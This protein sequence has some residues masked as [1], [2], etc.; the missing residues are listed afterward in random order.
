MS[1]NE[2][3]ITTITDGV[4]TLTINRPQA[5]NATSPEML[6][7]IEE[8]F[9]RVEK[10]P[11]ARCLVI[12]AAGEHFIAGGD[13]G[14][15]GPALQMTPEARSKEFGQRVEEALPLYQ[16]LNRMPK[17]IVVVA[18]GAIAG[19]GIAMALAADLTLISDTAFYFFAH[20]HLGLSLDGAL[21]YYLP[22]AVGPRKA[23]ELALLNARVAAPE[24]LQIGLANRMIADAELDAQADKLIKQ[25]ASGATYAMART[26][27]L[28]DASM[29]NSLT[30]QFRLEGQGVAACVATDDWLEGVQAFLG[31]RKPIFHG[32]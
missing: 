11:Q 14:S 7:G 10:D 31:K 26:K 2:F 9:L 1:T 8:F 16:S 24:A 21:S 13:V 18:R 6:R 17:P 32:R 12:R 30:D 25:L 22:R 3:L 19:A 5:R 20:G 23:A 4:A 27:A 28:I 29:R 15:F